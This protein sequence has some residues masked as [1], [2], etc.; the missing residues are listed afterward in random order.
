MMP[1]ARRDEEAFLPGSRIARYTVL[2]SVGFGGVGI[3][4]ACYDPDL[5]RKVAVKLLRPSKISGRIKAA[6]SRRGRLLREAQALARL[7]HPNVVPIYEVG[8]FRGQVYLVMEFVEGTTLNRWLERERHKWPAIVDRFSQAARGLAAAHV[9]GIVHRDFKPENVL[10]GVDNRVRVLDFGLATPLRPNESSIDRSGEYPADSD[11]GCSDSGGRIDQLISTFREERERHDSLAPVTRE[12]QIMGTPAYM[13]PEQA[14]GEGADS[15]SD[16]FSLCV[17]LYEAVYGVRPFRGKYDDPARF[18]ELGRRR[19]LPGKRP[20]DLSLRVEKAILRGLSLDPGARFPS[21]FAL[22]EE[23]DPRPPQRRWWALA[24]GLSMLL[25][26]GLGWKLWHGPSAEPSPGLCTPSDEGDAKLAALWGEPRVAA[27]EA[28]LLASPRPYTRQTWTTVRARFDSWAQ[29]WTAA[30]EQACAE[31]SESAPSR[32]LHAQRMA[33]FERQLIRVGSVLDDL[34]TSSLEGAELLDELTTLSDHLPAAQQCI[35]DD[36][37][38]DHTLSHATPEQEKA[39]ELLR[40]RIAAIEGRIEAG[41]REGVAAEAEILAAQARGLDY[42]YVEAE[43]VFTLGYALARGTQDIDRGV[44]LLQESAALAQRSGNHKALIR[45]ATELI[46][47]QGITQAKPEPAKV[48]ATIAGATLDGHGDDPVLRGE[49]SLSLGKLATFEGDYAGAAAHFQSAL[50]GLERRGGSTHPDFVPYSAALGDALRE[51]GRF[52]EAEAAL[53]AARTVVSAHYGDTHPAYLDS[54][55]SLANLL[56]DQNR[57]EEALA[58]HRQARD[59]AIEIYGEDHREVA[60]VLNNMAINYDNSGRYGEAAETLRQARDISASQEHAE[61]TRVAFIDVNLGSALQNL[62]RFDEALER[63][64]SAL[65]AIRQGLGED[66]MAVGVTLQNIA[67]ARTDRGQYTGARADLEA[68]LPLYDQAESN[69]GAVLG[70]EH[71]SLMSLHVDRARALR[72][73]GRHGEAIASSREAVTVAQALFESNDPAL[74]RPLTGL[75]RSLLAAYAADDPACPD[76]ALEEALGLAQRAVDLASD[77]NNSPREI[78]RA[79]FVLALA[80]AQRADEPRA[81]ASARAQVERAREIM[82]KAE[83]A[84]ILRREIETWLEDH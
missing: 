56:T 82:A 19:K 6:E 28:R 49:L 1:V 18:V 33:C 84:V 53:T 71:R 17:A 32:Q 50:D 70:A 74:V 61:P 46:L 9:A 42:E 66:H 79:R 2:E 72:S 36:L 35:A 5:D 77:A 29:S 76:G 39:A 7:S 83:G 54:L 68:A 15:R 48:W 27:F 22:I 40:K 80:T 75:S 37:L 55:E 64:Q 47:A 62:G 26:A 81:Q 67:A 63:Y 78:A 45:A 41:R 69:L 24:L 20:P 58:A 65:A 38:G 16:Q 23:L 30:R 52:D 13:S 43:A 25:S 21:M 34:Q 59:L 51:L 60:S 4:Y 3:V 10:V 11:P 8:T 31:G 57:N 73:L 12:G 44:N 14:R